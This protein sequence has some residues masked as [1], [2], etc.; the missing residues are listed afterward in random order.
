LIVGDADDRSVAARV[1]KQGERDAGIA[2]RTFD[3]R[4]ARLEA[5]GGFGVVDDS[6]RRAIFNGAAGI[7][8]FGLADDRATQRRRKF[9]QNDVRRGADR[10][11]ETARRQPRGVRRAV[12]FI[13]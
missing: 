3:D 7:E 2:R 13:Y 1:R 4:S 5:S 6:L 10:P 11:R 9:R 8:E 12:G